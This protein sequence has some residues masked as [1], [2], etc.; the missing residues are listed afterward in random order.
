[1]KKMLLMLI[2]MG[3]FMIPAVDGINPVW[4]EE[5]DALIEVLQ[6]KGILTP[7]EAKEVLS[8]VQI[9]KERIVK[10]TGVC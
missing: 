7:Q 2:I 4:A 10:R 8:E 3:I 5:T 1:M 6:K 9:Q